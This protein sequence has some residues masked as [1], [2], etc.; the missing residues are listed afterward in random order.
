M[1]SKLT[2]KEFDEKSPF[3]TILATGL[4]AG[5]L[6]AIAAIINYTINGGKLPAGIFQYI[7]SGAVGKQAF[8]GGTGMVVLGIIFHYTIAFAFTLF[9][10]LVYPRINLLSKNKI[11]TGIAYGIFV[12]L[13]MNLIVLP[14]SNIPSSP[15]NIKQA[16]IAAA[17]LIL[18]I[19]L[20]VSMIIGRYYQTEK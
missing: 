6:D 3:K 18:A 15:F 12:W 2:Y 10:F 17:I 13:I 4:I 19:G 8:T 7:A 5:T 11:L 16:I 14:M 9:F 20:P 1:S